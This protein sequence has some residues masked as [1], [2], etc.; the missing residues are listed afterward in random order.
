MADKVA[1]GLRITVR[2]RERLIAAATEEKRTVNNLVEVILDEWLDQIDAAKKAQE[3][4][5]G[6]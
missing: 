5:D 2:T 3:E 1:I 6:S 4:Q